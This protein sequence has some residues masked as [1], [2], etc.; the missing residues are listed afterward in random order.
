MFYW[1]LFY[2]VS[3]MYACIYDVLPWFSKRIIYIQN[4]LRLYINFQDRQ[5]EFLIHQI[6]EPQSFIFGRTIV[7]CPNDI[8]ETS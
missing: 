1:I 7:M 4:C 6:T 8:V 5:H 2:F 3:V